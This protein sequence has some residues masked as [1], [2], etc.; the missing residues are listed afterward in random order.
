VEKRDYRRAAVSVLASWLAVLAVVHGAAAQSPAVLPSAPLAVTGRVIGLDSRWDASGTIVTYV[1]IQ[2][3][4][5]LRGGGGSRLVLKQLGGQVGAVGLHIADQAQFTLGEDALLLLTVSPRDGSLHTAG[6]GRGKL[7]ADAAAIALVESTPAV[8]D[9]PP[10]AAV[11]AEFADARFAPAYALLPTEGGYPARW[12]EVDDNGIVRVDH[13]S[14]VPGTW[15]GGATSHVGAAIALWRGS[16]MELDLRDNGASLPAGQCAAAFT[17]NGRIAVSYNDPCGISDEADNWV[18]GG[19]YYTTGDLRTVNGTTF[20]K[21]IQGFLV[22]N[23]V[24]PQTGSAGC[25]QDAITHGLGHALGLGH[26]DSGGAMMNPLPS[27]SCAS[28]PRGLSGDDVSGITAIYRGIAS[29]PFPPAAPTALTAS[30]LLSTVTLNWTPSNDGGPAQRYFIDA[31][32]ASG[33]FNLGS[34]LVPAPATSTQVNGVPPGTYF[35]RVRAQNAMGTS[36]PSPQA[37]VSVGSCTAP[38][39]TGP[40]SATVNSTTVSLQWSAPATGLT[41]GYRFI[42]GTAPGLANVLVA[43]YPAS[44]TALAAAGVPY[45]TYYA[46]VAATNACGV[47]PTSNELTVVVQPCS[48]APQAPTGM[49]ATVA[50]S[51]VSLAWN[52]PAA[53][54]VPASYVIVVGSAPGLSNVLVYPTGSPATVLGAVAP[55]GVYYVRVQAQNPCGLS[56]VSNEIV[57]TVP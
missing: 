41:Q 5:W 18:I 55:A 46:R 56:G 35:V 2:V 57:V 32:T 15:T 36:G 7:A 47:G 6:L 44:V 30:A 4:R 49:R 26:S 31:G 50:G 34:I 37:Q 3:G 45:G 10:Y 28:G 11:P 51:Q 38:G 12:H 24:G 40:L 25:F 16:G 1:D 43:D 27:G 9:P 53:G 8:L 22:L 39:A 48:A 52:A 23:N 29:G 20:Q 19:G 21:F 54:P 17:G 13:P 14:A 33:V 42:V